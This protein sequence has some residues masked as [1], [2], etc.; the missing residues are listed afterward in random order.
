[1]GRTAND[2]VDDARSLAFFVWNEKQKNRG[3]SLE[4]LRVNL[5]FRVFRA[6]LLNDVRS[7]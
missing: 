6:M 3:S 1:M 7:L 4:P 5:I 2:F